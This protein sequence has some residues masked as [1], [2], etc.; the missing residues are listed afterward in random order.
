MN[1]KWVTTFYQNLIEAEL[2]DSNAKIEECLNF[3]KQHLPKF[4]YKYRSC[5][6]FAYNDLF[7]DNPHTS[8][9]HF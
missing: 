9:F 1:K 2:S 4:I 8:L 5:N 6:N 7:P 3:K